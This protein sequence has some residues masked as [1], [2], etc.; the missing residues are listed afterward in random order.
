VAE[1]GNLSPTFTKAFP[2][3]GKGGLTFGMINVVGS[4]D[5]VLA[6]DPILGLTVYDFSKPKTAY[7]PLTI[8]GQN[9]TCWVEYSKTTSSYWLS[10]LA[11]SKIYEVAVDTGTLK[12]TLL[13]TFTLSSL[14]R[15]NDIAIG[16]IFG[17]E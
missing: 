4:P 6:T 3:V 13:S 10:D 16:S 14:S 1:D 9:A 15:P 2:P 8:A 5:A 11:T 7:L 17:K 12:S